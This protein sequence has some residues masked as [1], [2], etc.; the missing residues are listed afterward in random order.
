MELVAGLFSIFNSIDFEV[1]AQ[2]TMVSLVLI[3]GPV[4]IFVLVARGGNM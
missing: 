4:V 1:V 2:L 3:A